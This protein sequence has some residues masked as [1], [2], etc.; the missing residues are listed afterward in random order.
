MVHAMIRQGC[1]IAVAAATSPPLLSSSTQSWSAQ[2]AL[3]NAVAEC[4][5]VMVMEQEQE[6]EQEHRRRREGCRRRALD[7]RDRDP[8]KIVT[9]LTAD[10]TDKHRTKGRG[11]PDVHL[12]E[13]VKAG[14]LPP[15]VST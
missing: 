5:V 10:K 3:V 9:D 14:L 15:G 12:G 6:Q 11:R 4:G 13:R 2:V 7:R 1:D 8:A